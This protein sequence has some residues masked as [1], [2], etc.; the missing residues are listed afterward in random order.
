MRGMWFRF[1]GSGPLGP[2]V[3]DTATKNKRTAVIKGRN[4]ISCSL[5]TRN[6]RKI[7]FLQDVARL[8]STT[9]PTK[10]AVEEVEVIYDQ[11]KSVVSTQPCSSEAHFIN[12]SK[13]SPRDLEDAMILELDQ[14]ENAANSP[15][16]MEMEYIPLN[17][18]ISLNVETL[19][20]QSPMIASLSPTNQGA[21]RQGSPSQKSRSR[22]RRTAN[23]KQFHCA[24]CDKS[25]TSKAGLKSH[26]DIHEGIRRFKCDTCGSRFTQRATLYTHLRIHSGAKPFLCKT[27][28]RSFRDLSTYTR[29]CRTHTGEKPYKC[30]S[31]GRG[32]SQ[33]G[34]RQRHAKNCN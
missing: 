30:G 34:N 23:P 20:R 26:L 5:Q 3:C 6:S 24:E 10:V 7:S 21:E 9:S 1:Q 17:D 13:T 12:A 33:S 32:F 31:C 14:P 22:C 8:I 16:L 28:S 29:H 27:C 18:E 15:S 2:L 11:Q 4:N 19:Q 25:F